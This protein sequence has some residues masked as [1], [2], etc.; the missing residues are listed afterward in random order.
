MWRVDIACSLPFTFRLLCVFPIQIL[1][2]TIVAVSHAF[3]NNGIASVA[4]VLFVWTSAFMARNA[5]DN[6]RR[7][8]PATN[9]PATTFLWY[10]RE[11]LFYELRGLCHFSFPSL[12]FT[13]YLLSLALDK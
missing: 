6:G 10:D 13:F 8:L 7:A 3:R 5:I 12:Y 9:T 4:F 1:H 2:H 11:S